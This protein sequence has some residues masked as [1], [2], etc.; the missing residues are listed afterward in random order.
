MLNVAFYVYEYVKNMMFVW[1][2]SCWIEW[3]FLIESNLENAPKDFPKQYSKCLDVKRE[4][5]W[6]NGLTKGFSILENT[7]ENSHKDAIDVTRKFILNLTS[8][9]WENGM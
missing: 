8:K 2:Q 9:S 7:H 6:E 4:R 5:G 1:V 3:K